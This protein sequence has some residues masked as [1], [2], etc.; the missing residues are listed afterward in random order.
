MAIVKI[1]KFENPFELELNRNCKIVMEK[2]TDVEIME[3][4]LHGY[5][6]NKTLF[7]VTGHKELLQTEFEVTA[8]TI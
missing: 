8:L 6:I 7:E 1:I 2:P 4:E 3:W 5:L